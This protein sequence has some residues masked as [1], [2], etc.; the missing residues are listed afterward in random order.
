MLAYFYVLDPCCLTRSR[1]LPCF[2]H[3]VGLCLLAFGTTWLF[4]HIRPSYGLFGCNHCENVSPWCWFARCIPSSTPCDDL[5]AL[6]A[7]CHLVWLSLFLCI[8]AHLPICSC[9]CLYVYLFVSSSLVPTISCEFTL[10]L[11]TQ[12]PKSLLET[13]LNGTCIIHTPISLNYGRQIQ[14]YILSS[15]DTPFQGR[16]NRW[17]NWCNRLRPPNKRRPHL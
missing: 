10:V 16:P 17:C 14:I 5:L 7:L 4:G 13:L 6:L 15:K 1:L 3:S 9:M 2:V 12:D 8:F 11:D